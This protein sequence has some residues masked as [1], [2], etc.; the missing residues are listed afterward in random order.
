MSNTNKEISEILRHYWKLC[1]NT[2]DAARILREV[3][4]HDAISDLTA[5]NWYN[6]FKKGSVVDHGVICQRIEANPDTSTRQL[7]QELG[8]F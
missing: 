3:E 2:V 8:P 1:R 7:S 6:K 5:Q 4:G